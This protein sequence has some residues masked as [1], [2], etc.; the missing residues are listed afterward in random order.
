MLAVAVQLPVVVLGD[1]AACPPSPSDLEAAP[2]AS[3]GTASARNV[4]AADARNLV[5]MA[6]PPCSP[7]SRRE[8]QQNA[9]PCPYETL[10]PRLAGN[11]KPRCSGAS[12]TASADLRQ[13]RSS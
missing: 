2:E 11:T 4:K 13:R 12:L 1:V 7:R 9:G 6:I 3:A 5:L 8:W 10:K